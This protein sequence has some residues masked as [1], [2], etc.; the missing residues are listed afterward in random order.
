MTESQE[1]LR[2]KL[3][4][5]KLFSTLVEIGEILDLEPIV[6][7]K[8]KLP[9]NVFLQYENLFTLEALAEY[10]TAIKEALNPSQ[11]PEAAVT[12]DPEELEE[13]LVSAFLAAN[14]VS[15]PGS[16]LPASDL[17]L[18]YSVFCT[19][20]GESPEPLTPFGRRLSQLGWVSTVK[21]KGIKTVRGFPDVGLNVTNVTD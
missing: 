9:F 20:Q 8:D 10:A 14:V 19:E 21:R 6:Q 15:I 3:A 16:F 4:R 18:A 13:D 2:M 7:N 5:D 17:Y 1:K 11:E 12:E